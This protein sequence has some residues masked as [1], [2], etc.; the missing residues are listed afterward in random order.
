MPSRPS[1]AGSDGRSEARFQV[2]LAR[3][4]ARFQVALAFSED[5]VE[6]ARSGPQVAPLGTSR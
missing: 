4:E 1:L 6:E 2:A 3:S 5:A